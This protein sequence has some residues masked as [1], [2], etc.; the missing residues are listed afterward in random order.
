MYLI[1]SHRLIV[2]LLLLIVADVPL[3]AVFQVSCVSLRVH[4]ISV[5]FS[6]RNYTAECPCCTA[7]VVL[8]LQSPLPKPSFDL[9]V[10]SHVS[11][12]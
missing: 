5:A 1:V 3:G 4:I 12:Y 2:A 7:V 11:F 9:L 10:R 6:F 8:L